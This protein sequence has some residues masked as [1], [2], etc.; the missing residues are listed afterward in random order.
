MEQFKSV[1]KWGGIALGAALS[2]FGIVSQAKEAGT[3]GLPSWAWIAIGWA[4]T[5]AA[6]LFIIY[7]FW[8]ENT[9]LRKEQSPQEI[10]KLREERKKQREIYADRVNVPKLLLQLQEYTMSE[11]KKQEVPEE[12]AIPIA[13]EFFW[14]FS[15]SALV[16]ALIWYL[17]PLPLKLKFRMS[18]LQAQML[19]NWSAVLKRHNLGAEVVTQQQGYKDLYSQIAGYKIGL[20]PKTVALINECV[21]ASKLLS[22]TIL[23]TTSKRFEEMLQ[24][25][26]RVKNM[27]P[28]LIEGV[29]LNAVMLR[30]KVSEGIEKFLLGESI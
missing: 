13:K 3:W 24:E 8:R 16:P 22:S 28:Y 14:A 30:S 5:I 20:P 17:L 11:V 19:L 26:G 25:Q 12:E 6:L 29:D 27:L 1:I 18:T 7:G 9:R 21:L 4:I 10:N 23:F 2:I 15:K